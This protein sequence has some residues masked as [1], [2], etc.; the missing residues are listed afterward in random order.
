MEEHAQAIQEIDASSRLPPASHISI[1]LERSGASEHADGTAATK[2][3]T[4]SYL[5]PANDLPPRRSTSSLS[6]R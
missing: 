1:E 4:G 6:D 2:R 3:Q 5:L